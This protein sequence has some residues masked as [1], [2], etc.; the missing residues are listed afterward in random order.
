MKGIHRIIVMLL[1]AMSLLLP[2]AVW[3]QKNIKVALALPKDASG[4]DFINGMYEV[5]KGDVETRTNGALTVEIIYGGA[6]G[7]P[8]NR[9]NQMRNGVIQMSDASDGNY[10]TIYPDIQVLNIPYLFANEQNAWKVLD[11]PFGQKLA[12]DLRTKIGIRVLG[13]WES[14]GF[15]HFSANRPLRSAADFTGLKIR[16]LG[17]LAT[18]LI[19]ALKASVVPIGFG[20]LYAAVS[21]GLVDVQDNSLS[22]F[23]RIKLQQVHKFILKSGH[24]YAV[25]VLGINDAFYIQLSPDE[26]A[27]VDA[28]ALKAIGFN[29]DGSRKAEQEAIAA[30]KTTGI[31]FIELTSEEKQEFKRITQGAVIEWLKTQVSVHDLIDEA[32]LAAQAAR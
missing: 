23:Q 26:R 12:D 29:R 7:A 2:Q 21:T 6:L 1:L 32:L 14:G 30:L 3:A 25:G 11:G 5:F 4:V 9:M 15:K 28:A 13:W 24:S 27:A 31:E 19:E 17:P 22:V 8:I 16:A 18:P 20:E 10:A